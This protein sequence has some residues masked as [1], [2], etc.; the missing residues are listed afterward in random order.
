M[1]RALLVVALAVLAM[2][3]LVPFVEALSPC[4]ERCLG[5]GPGNDCSSDQCCSCCVHS[6]FMNGRPTG[7]TE[8]LSPSSRIISAPPAVPSPA[9][10]REILH[11]PKT[12]AE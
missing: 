4:E 5:G 8:P 10:P 12:A 7:E 3:T 9:D 11:I 2:G 1:R 6:R